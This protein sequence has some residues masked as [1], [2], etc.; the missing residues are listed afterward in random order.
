MFSRVRV[1][2]GIGA[3]AGSLLAGAALAEVPAVVGTT[4]TG[5]QTDALAMVDLM[6]PF[7]LAVAGGILLIKIGKRVINKV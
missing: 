2:G 1:F 6:W 3:V 7:V 5:L 4:I